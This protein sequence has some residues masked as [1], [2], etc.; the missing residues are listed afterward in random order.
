MFYVGEQGKGNQI[1]NLEIILRDFFAL[2][3]FQFLAVDRPKPER[4][5]ARGLGLVIT[6][7]L[8]RASIQ[9]S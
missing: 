5:V 1:V 9:R 6:Y 2:Q 7:C 4:S 3:R 8:L